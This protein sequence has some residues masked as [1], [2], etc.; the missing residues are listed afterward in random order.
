M[1]TNEIPEGITHC[2]HCDAPLRK[3]RH[4]L[5]PGLVKTLL[6]IVEYIHRRSEAGVQMPNRFKIGDKD[7]ALTISEAG[8]V[9]KLKH[10]NLIH[11]EK[12][13]D[14][15]KDAYWFVTRNA[16]KFLRGESPR[17]AAAETYRGQKISNDD[18]QEQVTIERFRGKIG[19]FQHDWPF[20][21]HNPQETKPMTKQAPRQ[22]FEIIDKAPGQFEVHGSA[23]KTYA[24]T[25]DK[26]TLSCTCEGFRF[27]TKRTCKH[28]ADVAAL[29]KRRL[30]DE[31]SRNQPTIF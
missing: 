18:E 15:K 27:S 4:R 2:P 7:L 19:E 10:F 17:P 29:L 12:D 25:N 16:G 23:G 8:N 13:A 22:Q 28:T 21:A 31:I 1:E 26:G 20:L 24:V 5:T 11:A 30:A 14:G 9:Y 3:H 6:K